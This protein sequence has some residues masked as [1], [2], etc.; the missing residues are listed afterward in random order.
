MLPGF[1]SG[2]VGCFEPMSRWS[3]PFAEPDR[4]GSDSV[5]GPAPGFPA[6][7]LGLPSLGIP[8]FTEACFSDEILVGG[9][10][11]WGGAAEA[12]DQGSSLVEENGGES[13]PGGQVLTVSVRDVRVEFPFLLTEGI[14]DMERGDVIRWLRMFRSSG[15]GVPR[16]SRTKK[17][18][19]SLAALGLAGGSSLPSKAG[20]LGTERGTPAQAVTEPVVWSCQYVR[21]EHFSLSVLVDGD[22]DRVAGGAT[23]G[24][25]PP[26]LCCAISG[27]SMHSADYV[28][29]DDAKAGLNQLG[30]SRRLPSWPTPPEPSTAYKTP[31]QGLMWQEDEGSQD[32]T[33]SK[34]SPSKRPSDTPREGFPEQSRLLR[35]SGVS[36]DA[37]DAVARMGDGDADE[38]GAP[39]RGGSLA[40]DEG[41]RTAS[42]PAVS[43]MGSDFSHGGG[44]EPLARSVSLEDRLAIPLGGSRHSYDSRRR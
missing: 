31:R 22:G 23:D 38:G 36:A 13:G 18:A 19:G 35:G 34:S 30:R 27:I 29:V 5:E 2:S 42:V 14:G 44:K 11:G 1:S 17:R 12:V 20:A 25:V 10:R 26:D 15:K 28:P 7:S 39:P 24:G 6:V 4:D 3:P 41:A 33:G 9:G 8:S 21:A 43:A 40:A 32:S 37:A 16:A